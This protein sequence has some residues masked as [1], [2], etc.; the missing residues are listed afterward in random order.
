MKSIKTRVVG[1]FILIIVITIL[2]FEVL[3]IELLQSYYYKNT[4]EIVTNQIKISSDFYSRYF[5]NVSLKDNILDNVDV[6][7]NQTES[8]VQILDLEGNV[9][10]DSIGVIHKDKLST[11]DVRKALSGDHATWIGKVNYDNHEVMAVSHPL[12][13]SNKQIGVIRFVTSLE[14]INKAIINISMV[15]IFIG[16]GVIIIAISVSYII[17]NTIVSPIKDVTKIA[18]Q[19]AEG[20]FKVR[21]SNEYDDEIGKLNDTLNYMAE[22]ITKKEQLKNEFISS[23]SHE[24][25]TPLTSIK[26]WASTLNTDNND[27]EEILKDGLIII[28]NETER[29]TKMVEELLDFSRFNSGKMILKIQET[30]FKDILNYIRIN[31]MP[32]AQ[33]ANLFFNVDFK[34]E[35]DKVYIDRD[36]IKQVLINV[37]DNAFRF[38]KPKGYVIL[39]S[40]IKDDVLTIEIKDNGCGI[41]NQELPKVK[42]KFYKG[43]TNK[44][45]TGLGLSISDEI[46]KMHNGQINIESDLGQGTKVIIKIPI[47]KKVIIDE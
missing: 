47:S 24:L 15:F 30:N 8:Q 16:L 45:N 11:S 44:S 14:K 31:M 1:A 22:E 39:I 37:L 40:Q 20:N 36:R 29:L 35:N 12:I 27:N 3:L 7:W 4:E 38:T 28:E 5:S 34:G 13:S 21:G 18:E 6:F 41:N 2:I 32:R 19:M 46:I 23:I 33:R 25:R 17:S 26:G 9:L 42:E 10:M 43:K